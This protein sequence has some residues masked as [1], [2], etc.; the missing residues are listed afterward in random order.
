MVSTPPRAQPEVG[1]AR[2]DSAMK[3]VVIGGSGLI[4]SK[5][6]LGI[7]DCVR[8]AHEV[9]TATAIASTVSA[10]VAAASPNSSL[11]A[12]IDAADR[13][14]YRAKNSGR[15]RVESAA[16]QTPRKATAVRVA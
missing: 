12:A 13:A 9:A 14:L 3:I 16:D 10:G 15:N 2:G 7:A 6:A 5:L 8:R 4:G 11:D 1:A